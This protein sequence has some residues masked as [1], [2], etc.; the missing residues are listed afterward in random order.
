MLVLTDAL[1]GCD[2]QLG[3]E[4]DQGRG[5][6]AAVDEVAELDQAQVDDTVE[7]RADDGVAELH[8]GDLDRGLGS[9][10]RRLGGG[11]L[12]LG[13]EALLR[14]LAIRIELDLALRQQGFGLR[15][16]GRAVAGD[17]SAMMSP[18][19]TRV[20]SSTASSTMRPSVSERISTRRS[21]GR[22]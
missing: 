10:Q 13:A 5:R 14:Q 15:Q 16:Q 3:V 1:P 17:S 12:C 11:E 19:L 4:V 6:I 18:V 22:P 7:G 9:L 20:P 21:I 8:L 2:D